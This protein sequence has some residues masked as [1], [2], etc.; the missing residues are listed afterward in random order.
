MLYFHIH[1][2]PS[3]SPQVFTDTKRRSRNITFSWSPPAPTELNGVI[4]GYFLSC[5][6]EAGGR[7]TITMQY[8][9]A[10]TF[11]LGGFTPFTSYNCSIS[12][13]NSQGSGPATHRVVTTLDDG[14]PVTV[15]EVVHLHLEWLWHWMMVR[16]MHVY[17]YLIALVFMQY[18]EIIAR[19]WGCIFTSPKDIHFPQK[20]IIPYCTETSVKGD[21]FNFP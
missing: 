10:G 8:T 3:G 17:I 14:K 2:A 13:S 18:W 7:N 1:A 19:V 6:P 4:T 5:V 12:A 11:T 20:W 15:R 9:A 21:L 16:F